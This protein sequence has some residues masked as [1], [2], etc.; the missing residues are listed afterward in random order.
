M[1]AM[2]AVWAPAIFSEVRTVVS[3]HN[4]SVCLTGWILDPYCWWNPAGY[5]ATLDTQYIMITPQEC[6]CVCID[7]MDTCEQ[8]PIEASCH[9]QYRAQGVIELVVPLHKC[10]CQQNVFIVL[11]LMTCLHV[12]HIQESQLKQFQWDT[13]NLATPKRKG[14]GPRMNQR[15][16]KQSRLKNYIDLKLASF[17]QSVT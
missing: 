16:M 10:I 14:I 4:P 2:M 5:P 1:Y 8:F 15:V 17:F 12:Q 13:M 6:V 7:K 9:T 3:P 11:H